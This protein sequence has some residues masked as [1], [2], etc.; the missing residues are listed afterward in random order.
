MPSLRR[1]LLLING[2]VLVAALVFG[3]GH[4]PGVVNSATLI[5]AGSSLW[6]TL[7][8]V[9]LLRR[10][11]ASVAAVPSETPPSELTDTTPSLEHRT[12]RLVTTTARSTGRLSVTPR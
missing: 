9:A 4:I 8:L 6:A 2:A 7:R 1:E 11:F 10:M 12:P 5:A 3:V